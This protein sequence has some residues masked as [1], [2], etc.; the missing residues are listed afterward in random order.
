MQEEVTIEWIGPKNPKE[1]LSS[2]RAKKT[3]C[4]D[5]YNDYN[6]AGVYMWV[7]PER[8]VISYVGKSLSSM[9]YRQVE[10]CVSYMSGRC[11][12]PGDMN[13]DG[14]EWH[15][16]G[17]DFGKILFDC[18]EFFNL[19]EKILKLLDQTQVYFYMMEGKGS[20]EINPLENALIYSLQ[21]RDN[22]RG[23]KSPPGTNIK[24]CHDV[25]KD[26]EL[27]GIMKA[28]V[29]KAREKNPNL[30]ELFPK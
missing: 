28:H 7:E 24:L 20:P 17:D 5:P 27:H 3:G 11:I 2:W 14:K 19:R 29:M 30:P 26:N 10:W 15:P 21:P 22:R 23:R 1:F 25:G 9:A 12:I 4:R 8:N 13:V 16:Y 18:E 6:H